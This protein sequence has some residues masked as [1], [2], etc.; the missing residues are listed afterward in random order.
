MVLLDVCSFFRISADGSFG[1][2]ALSRV[3]KKWDEKKRDN[4]APLE[5][6]DG[7]PK[8]TT[9]VR[10]RVN[11]VSLNSSRIDTMLEGF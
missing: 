7:G 5:P 10:G 4:G 9:G 3:Y 2:E 11:A 8:F 1:T 6:G